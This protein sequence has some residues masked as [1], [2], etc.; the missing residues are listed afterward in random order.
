[1]IE[2]TAKQMMEPNTMIPITFMSLSDAFL[3]SDETMFLLGRDSGEFMNSPVFS[4]YLYPIVTVPDQSP[5][6]RSMDR[7]AYRPG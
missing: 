6:R 2:A 7:P 5:D 3:S 4:L 1:M